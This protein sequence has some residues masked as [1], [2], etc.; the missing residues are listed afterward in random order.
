MGGERGSIEQV[1]LTLAQMFILIMAILLRSEFGRLDHLSGRAVIL[2][3]VSPQFCLIT[4]CIEEEMI[5]AGMEALPGLSGSR[6]DFCRFILK[7]DGLPYRSN[8]DNI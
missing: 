2:L 6:A 8:I 5:E 1:K 4:V 3:S 7:L